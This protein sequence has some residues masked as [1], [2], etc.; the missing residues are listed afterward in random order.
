MLCSS[1]REQRSK[2]HK[3]EK[4]SPSPSPVSIPPRGAY[5]PNYPPSYVAP[6]PIYVSPAAVPPPYGRPAAPSPP[7]V[8][9]P[10]SFTPLSLQV[11]VQAPATGPAR[12]IYGGTPAAPVA[13]G[14]GAGGATGGNTGAPGLPSSPIS[15]VPIYPPMA[16]P[17]LTT[18][19]GNGVNATLAP[20]L[21]ANETAGPSPILPGTVSPTSAPALGIVPAQKVK[22]V[23]PEP[24]LIRVTGTFDPDTEDETFFDILRVNFAPYSRASI[25]DMLTSFDLDAEFVVKSENEM[26]SAVSTSWIEIKASFHIETEDEILIDAFTSESGSVLLTK[27]F[28]AANGQRLIQRLNEA[29]IPVVSIEVGSNVPGEGST[30]VDEGAN[31]ADEQ[32]VPTANKSPELAKGRSD[33]RGGIIAAAVSGAII[34]LAVGAVLAKNRQT[35]KHAIFDDKGSVTSDYSHTDVYSGT[36]GGMYVSS[37]NTSQV[38][39][40][41][42]HIRNKQAREKGKTPLSSSSTISSYQS[43]GTTNAERADKTS[44]TKS[45][46]QTEIT[47]NAE[48]TGEDDASGKWEAE[49]ANKETA[50][51]PYADGSDLTGNGKALKCLDGEESVGA[52]NETYP[53]FDLYHSVGLAPPS[54]GWS[55]GNF[56]SMSQQYGI[57]AADEDYSTSRKRWHDEANDLDLIVLPDHSSDQ[58]YASTNGDDQSQSSIASRVKRSI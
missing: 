33:N 24:I 17:S 23:T 35:Q 19:T 52:M 21:G 34:L 18:P 4:Y 28:Q 53:E 38:K 32:S 42:L 36:R 3:I 7:T 43:N 46:L 31:D 9:I 44:K 49:D 5:P 57:S 11:P 29:G 54:P 12:P 26:K 6:P 8:S 13:P 41:A 16:A 47:E 20:V 45:L 58:G 55:V 48:E 2:L 39:P 22:T 30:G 10:S 1:D 56:S 37:E 15:T 50:L 25:G 40:A 51:V 27:F 14:G